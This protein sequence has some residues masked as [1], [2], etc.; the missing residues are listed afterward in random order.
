MA[1]SAT[2]LQTI[3]D[4]TD[5]SSYAFPSQAFA[6]DKLYLIFVNLSH[7]TLECPAV[8]SISGGGLTWVEV[9]NVGYSGGTPNVRRV[10][11]YRALVSSG[12]T[13]GVVTMTVTGNTPATHCHA[14]LVEVDGVNTSGT[15]G[16]GAIGNTNTAIA[17]SATTLT[18]TLSAVGASN[19]PIAWFSHRAT[20]LSTEEAGYTELDDMSSSTPSSGSICEWHATVADVS[21]SASW[22]TA[23]ACGGIGA[24]LVAAA[25]PPNTQPSHP[26]AFDPELLAQGWF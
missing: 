19:R 18:A 2:K 9:A 6:N 15:N 25:E 22:V 3:N 13:T 16:S 10:Q 23:A 24:E 1:L 11:C 4:T 14:S 17:S 8:T 26:G 5:L 7:G 20:E 21:P 12:A